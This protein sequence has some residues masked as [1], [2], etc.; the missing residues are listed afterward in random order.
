M[1]HENSRYDLLTRLLHWI[2]AAG[3]IYAMIVGYL[4]HFIS[5]PVILSFFLR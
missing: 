2:V 1:K 3:I 5:N 4:L